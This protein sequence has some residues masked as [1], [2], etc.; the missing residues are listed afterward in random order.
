[1]ALVETGLYND[2]LK[3]EAGIL[4]AIRIAEEN[5]LESQVELLNDA[6]R[7]CRKQLEL[8]SRDR[9]TP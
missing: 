7:E 8:A 4:T 3:I 2:L 6:L 9:S 1:V 5:Q